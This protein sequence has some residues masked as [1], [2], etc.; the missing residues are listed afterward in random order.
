MSGVRRL[1]AQLA[2]DPAVG[3]GN[4]LTSLLAMGAQPEQPALTFDSPVGGQPAW[5]ALTLGD[6]DRLVAARAAALRALGVVR[7]DP[8][9]VGV[10]TA[11]DCA[12]T[13]LALARLGAIPALVNPGLAAES[14]AAYIRRIRAT[15]LISDPAVLAS[16]AGQDLGIPVLAHAADLD[17]G[18]PAAAP[19]PFAHY[20]EDPVAITHSSGTT[21]LPKAVVHSHH[22]LYAAIRYRLKLPRPQGSERMLS[23]LPTPHAAMLI[24]LNLG[25]SSGSEVAMLSRQTGPGILDAI[26]RW[27]P[28][29]V[30][31]FATTWANL[32]GEDLPAR[33]LSSV[34]LWWNTGDCAHEAHIRNLVTRGQRQVVTSRG[35]EVS[36]G[37]VFVDG[38]GSSEMGH[39]H[40]FIAH[41]P[42]T[43]RYGRCIGRPHPFAQVAVIGPDG[44]EL[45]PGEIGELGTRSPT[46]SL[47]YWNDSVTTYRTRVRGYFLT[48]DLVY[49]DQD[50][51]FYHLDRKVDAV[52]LGDG[53]FLYTAATEER[54]LARC[55]DVRD[56]TVI[57]AS[58]NGTVSTEV[59]LELAPGADPAADRDADVRAA[60]GAKAAA[61]LRKITVVPGDHIPLTPTGKVRKVALREQLGAR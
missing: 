34:A 20:G 13:F 24:A 60:L 14:A 16:W 46:L 9:V 54:L 45:P 53:D 58:E 57:A 5:Q 35:R 44:Q 12:L 15:G 1:A 27:Q 55:P 50:G 47:G 8:V 43:D 17:A 18:D 4:V 39:S 10:S 59:L 30:V 42:D 29:S 33:D 41:S 31:G 19:A 37:S 51:Y 61:T 6:L 38:L 56:C 21:G 22:S 40:F 26:E 32:A 23:A 7:R 48:G 28:R 3:A 11:A 52:D 25:L 36:P 2:A 49:T